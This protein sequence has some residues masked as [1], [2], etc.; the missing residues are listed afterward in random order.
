M[1]VVTLVG[2]RQ[3]GKTTLVRHAFPDH[4]YVSLE[5]PDLRAQ[6]LADPLGFLDRFGPRTILDEV[7]R[8]P[9]LA[10]Y[11]QGRVDDDGTPGRFILTGSQNFLLMQHVS[12]S[13]AGRVAVLHL[14]PLTVAELWGRPAVDVG[15]V[16]TI[17]SVRTSPRGSL[18]S[19]LVAGFYP[20]IHDR[21]LDPGEWL[22]D[23]R[24][25]YVERDLRDVLRVMDLAAFDR[26][27]RLAAAR[28]GQE[29]NLSDLASDT[30][31]SQPTA[32]QWL[33][34]LETGFLVMVLSQHHQSYRK[35]LRKRPKLHF[36]DT[37][38]TCHLLGIRD[39]S[40]LEAHP[41][42]GAIFESFVVGELAKGFHNRRMDPP[43]FHWRDATGHEVDILVD[44]GSRLMP[45]EVKSGKTVAPDAT[46]TL[47]WW[48]HIAGAP[49]ADA[50][51][52]HGGEDAYRLRGVS[53]LPW[54]LG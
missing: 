51:L 18:W 14:L 30:G 12:Q 6:A 53:V 31:I 37:G 1:P 32:R 35:R 23:Y 48:C 3:S 39:A 11:I 24:R 41:L 8:A 42:R 9:E 43:L 52:V 22:A 38:L 47:E 16:G 20:R 34:A 25:T 27:L 36:L 33:S 26:F 19:T 7:Q 5:R 13:L 10:S 49:I 28:T 54:Y 15:R 50:V 21:G 4:A 44:H 2:P 17:D 46:A 45:I 40:T 29:L